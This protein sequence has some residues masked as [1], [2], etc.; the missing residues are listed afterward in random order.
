[1]TRTFT[2]V[3][4]IFA[5]FELTKVYTTFLDI[6]T[7]QFKDPIVFAGWKQV[8][9]LMPAHPELAPAQRLIQYLSVW[10]LNANLIMTLL[11]LI[12]MTSSE[13]RVRIPAALSMI[14]GA[15]TFFPHMDPL[16]R[17][18]GEAGDF[19]AAGYAGF[20][21][22]E[23]SVTLIMLVAWTSAFLAECHTMLTGQGSRSAPASDAEAVTT[24][25]PG[26]TT[27]LAPV[28]QGAWAPVGAAV[29]VVGAF[30]PSLTTVAQ[31]QT[32]R[33]LRGV[34]GKGVGEGGGLDLV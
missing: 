29:R 20:G 27:F 31:S 34:G 7:K 10:T 8:A 11:I 3:G 19:A 33:D 13:S 9:N 14:I 22:D 4:L 1:M 12:A 23:H 21:S 24:R 16:L 32:Q 18:M 2:A 25:K 30:I 5:Y 6:E 28:V 26:V 17:S 15:L